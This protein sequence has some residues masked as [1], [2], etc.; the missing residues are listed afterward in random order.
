MEKGLA[1]HDIRVLDVCRDLELLNEQ[2]YL[3]LATLFPG[4]KD[5]TELW[6]KTA[7]EESN[8]AHQFELAIKA[9]KGLLD[10]V[11]MG[12]PKA[13][14]MYKYIQEVLDEVKRHPPGL[15]DALKGAIALED[16]LS[17]FHL[18]CVAG[19]VEESH[20]QLF[21]AMMAADNHHLMK[22]Q[23]TYKKCLTEQ[24]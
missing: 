13:E 17:E 23:D 21:R 2:L 18:D 11:S 1:P 20:K 7:R 12:L 22:L 3:Y 19:F 15:R 9:N 8:H 24:K 5:I 14:N 10:S 6:E 16:R 4:D